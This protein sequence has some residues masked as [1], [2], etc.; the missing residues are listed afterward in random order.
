MIWFHLNLSSPDVQETVFIKIQV[1]R[2]AVCLCICQHGG[3]GDSYQE[4]ARGENKQKS[5]DQKC[6][7]RQRRTQKYGMSN[8]GEDD[9]N[10]AD[11]DSEKMKNK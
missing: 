3:G 4:N 8:N 11:N 5:V 9:H 10:N 1:T 2:Q 6:F 7:S